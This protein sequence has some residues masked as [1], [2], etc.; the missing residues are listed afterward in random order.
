VLDDE[1]YF[2]LKN[3]RSPGNVGFY[4][5]KDMV[6]GDVPEKIRFRTLDKFPLKLMVWVAISPRGISEPFFCPRN[7]A[8]NGDIY[9]QDCIQDHLLPF[10]QDFHQDGD[11]YFFPDLASS[12]Y[13]KATTDLLDEENVPYIPKLAN[14]PN[15]PQL[16]PI[17]DFWGALKH[18]VYENGFEAATFN[19]LKRRIRL[20][21]KEFDLEFCQ[22]LFASFK[23]NLRKAADNGVISINH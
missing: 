13:A 11:Y 3:D 12:H 5:R 15:C 1:S 22:R 16:R 6:R 20:K 8:V 17:E 23:T 14:P 19:Q 21:L 4:K 2:F 10:L 9:R 18:K 7:M